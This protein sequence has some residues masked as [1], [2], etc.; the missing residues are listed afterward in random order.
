MAVKNKI[1][2]CY[3]QAV[4][5]IQKEEVRMLKHLR[6]QETLSD[7]DLKDCLEKL[8]DNQNIMENLIEAIDLKI[9]HPKAPG[10]EVN[11]YVPFVW[12]IIRD[13]FFVAVCFIGEGER[14]SG[15]ALHFQTAS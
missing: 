2:Q 3:G 13:L 5:A 6:E 15:Y 11:G 14:R 10:I 9:A 1:K 7:V 12:F 8:F 4:G